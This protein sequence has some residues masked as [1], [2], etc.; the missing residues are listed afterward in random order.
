MIVPGS[1]MKGNDQESSRAE[2]FEKEEGFEI[3]AVVLGRTKD[4]VDRS[5]RN[6]W[7]YR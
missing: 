5:I 3:V 4:L 6:C 7:W 1:R 2:V